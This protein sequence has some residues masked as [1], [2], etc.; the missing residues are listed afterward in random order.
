MRGFRVS[1]LG[2]DISS[3]WNID[4]D[5]AMKKLQSG[6]AGQ[7]RPLRSLGIDI[8]QTSLEM[9]AL[10]YGIEDSVIKMSQAAKVQLRWLSIMDQAEV[11]FGDMAKT[12]D[13]PANQLR[14]LEQGW[15]NLSRSI[16]NVMVDTV[17]HINGL[18]ARIDVFAK[19]LGFELPD[20][21]DSNIYTDVDIEGR[22]YRRRP[23]ANIKKSRDLNWVFS[24]GKSKG[25]H[26]LDS[27]MMF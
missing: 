2:T 3:L 18:I 7:I 8:S 26:Q 14:I 15:T 19:A 27:G 6:L 9:T 16:G 24:E 22:R 17:T 1:M 13:S 10:N 20:Y 23:K 21:S 25:K 4:I 12:I 5:V 11:A